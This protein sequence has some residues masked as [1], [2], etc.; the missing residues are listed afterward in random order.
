MKTTR[1]L[2]QRLIFICEFRM[3]KQHKIQKSFID[4]G[5]GF[6]IRLIFKRRT[7]GMDTV[8]EATLESVF[9]FTAL[10]IEI[11]WRRHRIDSAV[12]NC[13]RK[14]TNA[15]EGTI[16]NS[17]RWTKFHPRHQNLDGPRK[18]TGANK[19]RCRDLRDQGMTLRERYADLRL[20]LSSQVQFLYW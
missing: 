4:S 13:N 12:F 17:T 6:P 16:Q 1:W 14:G 20:P 5:F 9:A 18:V 2:L 3:N 10:K 19:S 15:I 11:N 8:G 7:K